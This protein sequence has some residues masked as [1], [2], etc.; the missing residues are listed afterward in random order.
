MPE[1]TFTQ[2]PPV[3]KARRKRWLLGMLLAL[4]VSYTLAVILHW[5]DRLRWSLAEWTTP[6]QERANAVWLPGYRADIDAKLMPGLETD[7]ASDLSYDPSSKTLYSVMG[8]HPFLVQLSLEGDVLRKIELVGWANP[9]GV[10]VLENGHIAIT[11]ERS[12]L[13]TIVTAPAGVTA[14]NIKDFPQF[15]LGKAREKNKGTEAVAWDAQGQRVL[16]GQERPAFLE[17]WRSD[18]TTLIGQPMT[19][20]GGPLDLR[21]LSGMDVDRRTGHLLLVSADSHLILE[22]DSAGKPVSYMTLL[23][24]FNGLKQTIPRA[25]GVATDEQGTLYVI[26][27]PNLFYRFKH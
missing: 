3:A 13:L 7:E 23:G 5:D 16:F 9:E 25:E 14:L 6:A 2:V 15:P 27:E 8:K 21:N 24:Y 26:S 1:Q 19:L 12:Q 10:A 22:T 17:S 11:D 18:G 4:L 20:A